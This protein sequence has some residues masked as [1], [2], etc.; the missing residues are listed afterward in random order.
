MKTTTASES[1]AS[2]P[3]LSLT[4]CG[5]THRSLRCKTCSTLFFLSSFPF[6]AAVSIWTALALHS[7]L[8]QHNNDIPSLV[9]ALPPGPG[10]LDFSPACFGTFHTDL[11]RACV[12]S[13]FSVVFLSEP[14]SVSRIVIFGPVPCLEHLRVDLCLYASCS[15]CC[16]RVA[17][18]LSFISI[19]LVFLMQLALINSAVM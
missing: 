13:N 2:P 14:V 3:C 9:A 4:A 12:S 5:T 6:F 10:S 1:E 15:P 11:L 18:R 17:M 19:C 8:F 7:A 16:P